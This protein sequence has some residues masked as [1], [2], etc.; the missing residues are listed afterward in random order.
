MRVPRPAPH[1]QGPDH[2]GRCGTGTGS[3]ESAAMRSLA[4]WCFGHRRLVL[5]LWIA[6]LVVVSVAGA[7]AGSGYSDSFKLPGTESTRALE[8]LQANFKTQSGDTN[9]VVFAGRLSDPA[10]QQRVRATLR[11]IA[12]SPHV[13]RVDD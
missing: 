11:R 10:T 6:T 13:E 8:L 5:A 9:Q 7:S 12:R 2:D 4:R 1:G 3:V